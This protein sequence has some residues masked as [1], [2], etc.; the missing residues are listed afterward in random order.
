LADLRRLVDRWQNGYSWRALE[1]ELAAA[2]QLRFS[3][4]GMHIHCL[5]H[6][7]TRANAIPLL[8]THGWPGSIVEF[9]DV[10][11]DLARPRD[12]SAPAFH[13]VAPS[14]PGFGFSSKPLQTGWDVGRIA[15]TWADLMSALGYER[16]FAHGGDWGAVVTTVLAAHHPKRVAAM[17]TTFPQVPPGL[18]RDGLNAAELAMVD[19]TLTFWK[20]RTAYAR[21]QATRPQTLAYALDDS[22]VG[23]LAWMLDKFAE[24]SDTDDTPFERI[25][26][27]RV[28]DNVT[29]HWLGRSGGSS[30]R[31]YWESYG[32][33]DPA[34]TVSVPAS[35][36]VYPHEIE[37]FPRRW[38]ASRYRNIVRWSERP[39]GGHFP[40]LEVPQDFVSELRAAFS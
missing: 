36:S 27:D 39:R 12:V 2:G 18:T 14:L 13:I 19:D 8:L 25:A 33:L 28:L 10:I 3:V 26:P 29:L 35:I 4:D 6:R 1:D 5:H 16:F 7:S 30:A 37:R 22:P 34:L 9:L 24:W 31:I 23:L 38:V 15:D 11:D 20:Q 40:S 21:Q 17:H 32:R